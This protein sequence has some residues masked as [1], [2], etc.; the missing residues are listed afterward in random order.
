MARCPDC[1]H[2]VGLE[3]QEPEVDA[4]IEGDSV[5]GDVRV[6]LA[7]AECGT[8]LKE[9]NLEFSELIDHICDG[10]LPKD[11]EPVSLDDY[12]AEPEDSYATKD[13]HG[14]P[15]KNPRYRTHFWGAD[16]SLELHCNRCGEDWTQ[17][18]TVEEAASAMEDLV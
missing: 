8:E 3:N 17:N 9:A 14:K 16:V 15:I 10:E 18:V 12:S 1:N 13:R 7:C 4:R 6:V 5:E 2:F 11:Q